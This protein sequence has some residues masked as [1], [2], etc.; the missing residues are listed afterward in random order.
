MKKSKIIIMASTV[1]LAVVGV[2]A[3]AN[4]HKKLVSFTAYFRTAGLNFA[5]VFTGALTSRL[6]TTGTNMAKITTAGGSHTLFHSKSVNK[7]LFYH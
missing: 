3:T 5:T 7:P 2:F 1:V 4:A 6:Q